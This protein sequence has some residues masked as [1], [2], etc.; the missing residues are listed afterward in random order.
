MDLLVFVTPG[1]GWDGGCLRLERGLKDRPQSMGEQ[2]CKHRVTEE[3]KRDPYLGEG[4][5][6]VR[7]K[8]DTELC[9]EGQARVYWVKKGGIKIDYARE[10]DQHLQRSDV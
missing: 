3:P 9:L 10:G 6:V 4:T 2:F 7:D 5:T 1:V 8:V